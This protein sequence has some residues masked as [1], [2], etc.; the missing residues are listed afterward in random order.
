MPW[1]L[2]GGLCPCRA[3]LGEGTSEYEI[4]K[5]GAHKGHEMTRSF[6]RKQGCLHVCPLLSCS[7]HPP[8]T[9]T[10][11]ANYM[12]HFISCHWAQQGHS[13][14]LPSCLNQSICSAP[15]SDHTCQLIPKYMSHILRLS[16]LMPL[17]GVYAP[18]WSAFAHHLCEVQSYF[19]ALLRK[20]FP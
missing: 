12:W 3:S 14:L 13:W 10:M 4:T 18:P 9:L 19:K 8:P 6:I 5:D 11:T 20:H 1:E 2:K 15:R 17:L 16:I 7:L